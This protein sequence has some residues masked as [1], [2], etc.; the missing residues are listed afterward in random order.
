MD[1]DRIGRDDTEEEEQ[2]IERA[3]MEEEVDIWA[4]Y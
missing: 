2:W 3:R 1:H 4:P